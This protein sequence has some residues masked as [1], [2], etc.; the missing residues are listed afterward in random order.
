MSLAG[1][2]MIRGIRLDRGK[3]Y[4]NTGKV[5]SREMKGGCF[6]A[7]VRRRRPFARPPRPKMHAKACPWDTVTW[8]RPERVTATNKC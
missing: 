6:P 7:L 4:A 3:S 2:A 8:R 5:L 1:Y